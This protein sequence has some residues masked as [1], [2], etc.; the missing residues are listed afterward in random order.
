MNVSELLASLPEDD[1]SSSTKAAWEQA[2]L[3]E[4]FADLANRPA[5]TGSLHRLWTMTELSS[6]VALAYLNRWIRGWF[7]DAE[8]SKRRLALGGHFKTDHTGSLQNR[9][10][11]ITLDKHLFYR[12][13]GS[14]SNPSSDL[15]RF[16]SCGGLER[17]AA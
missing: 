2:R 12:A 3:Q 11:G 17:F 9:P 8:A 1:F 6:Q 15:I 13:R 7:S 4:I 14:V 10:M 5:P 16:E